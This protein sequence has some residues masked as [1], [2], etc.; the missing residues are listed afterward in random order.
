MKQKAIAIFITAGLLTGSLPTPVR[1]V[2]KPMHP[3][4]EKLDLDGDMVLFL[5]TSTIE[6]RVLDYI[7]QMSTLMQSALQSPS[8]QPDL[9][10]VNEG[11]EKV[12][13]AIEWSG[14]LS[15]ESY[16][17]SMAPAG[18][19]LSRIVSI[20]RHSEADAAKPLWR[21][22]AS[23]PRVLK[24]IDYIP[25]NAVYTCNATTSLGEVWKVA[26]EAVSRFGEP[27]GAAAFN[28]QIAMA[29]MVLGTNMAAITESLENEILI[30]IQLSEDQQVVFPQGTNTVTFPEPS[31][32]FGLQTKEPLL[33]NI[34]LQKLTQFQIPTIQTTNGVYT[35]HTLNLPLP[36]PVPV[37]PTLVMTEDYL[38]IGSTREVV[39]E[40]LAVK[41]GKSGLVSTP[42]YQKLLAGAPEKTSGI[43]FL[44]PRFM[45]SYITVV[46]KILNTPQNAE[47]APMMDMMLAGYENM[48]AGSYSLKTPTSLFSQSYADYGGAKPVEMA[49]SS[50]VGLL[51]AIGIP[52]FQKARSNSQEKACQNNRRIIE[53][54]KEQWAIENGKSN[55]EAVTEADITGYIKGGFSSMQCPKGGTYTISPIGTAA[56]C[57]AHGTLR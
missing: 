10:M 42:L 48:Y 52:S 3:S 5:N 55:G 23:E 1:A 43:E 26:N 35:L 46:S 45:E 22:L 4:V 24:G 44:S 36:S 27:E 9:Q 17:M 16:A 41:V 56:E 32:L 2:E 50:Y 25:R 14:L 29:E 12:K 19:T 37:T 6:Q 11:T 40:A 33:G 47:M 20:A 28:Q 39:V 15:L 34:L 49:A 30:S 13:A 18:G 8:S 21:L 31:L 54:A 7:D 57:P 38:L 51:A 53:A